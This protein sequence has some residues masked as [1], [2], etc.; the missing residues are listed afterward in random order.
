MT[1]RIYELE[2]M[3]RHGASGPYRHFQ[4]MLSALIKHSGAHGTKEPRPLPA[5]TQPREHKSCWIQWDGKLIFFDMS[6]HVQL[7]DLNA[8]ALCSV[9]FK[10]NLHRGVANR[11][12]AENGLTEHEQKLAPFLYFSEGLEVFRRE[13][14]WRRIL[15]QDLPK[16]DLCFIMGVYENPI[17]DGGR[18]P[19]EHP[20]EPMTPAAYHFWIRWHTMQALRAAGISGYYRLTS[21][22]NPALEDGVNVCANLSRKEF[23][24]RITEGCI[25]AVCTFPH[26][27]FP[28]KASESFTLGRPILIEQ[29]PLTATPRPFMLKSGEH[30]LEFLPG[31]GDFDAMAPLSAAASYRILKRIPMALFTERA[32]WLKQV[33][34][35]R[36]H[37]EEMRLACRRFSENAYNK[38]SVAEYIQMEINRKASGIAGVQ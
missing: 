12:L 25:T 16:Y 19:F 31:S 36:N 30:F 33:L 28:W 7:M 20:D 17:R 34:S 18:S 23:S 10:A 1:V 27:L 21:R 13:A 9:Y 15:R 32:E 38:K 8:L 2:Q 29:S 24:R 6:D 22:A 11:I 4:Y 37:M 26:A 3:T 35:D 5:I 14:F